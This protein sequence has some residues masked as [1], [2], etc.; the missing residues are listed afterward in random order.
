MADAIIGIDV[1]DGAID[2]ADVD[3]RWREAFETM[4][5]RMGVKDDGSGEQRIAALRDEAQRTYRVGSS[6]KAP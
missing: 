4:S 2:P 5:H 1:W 3:R 6:A